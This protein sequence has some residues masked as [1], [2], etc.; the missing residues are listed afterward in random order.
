MYDIEVSYKTGNSFGSEEITERLGGE[1]K[2]IE[3]AKRAL[4]DIRAHWEYYYW[5]EKHPFLRE[6]KEMEPPTCCRGEEDDP[7]P[8]LALTLDNSNEW[9]FVPQWIGYFE[10]LIGAEVV[11]AGSLSY[12]P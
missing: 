5:R 1:W 2:T 11:L 6:P 9:I 4:D 3:A 8:A 10:R 12:E 7:L